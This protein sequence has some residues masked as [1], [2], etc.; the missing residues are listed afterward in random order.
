MSHPEYENVGNTDPVNRV[1]EE[2]GE[3]LFHLGKANRFGWFSCH[4][5]KPE[6]PNNLE[7]V[8]TEIQDLRL[9]LVRLDALLDAH[10]QQQLIVLREQQ[11]IHDAF[12]SLT[13]D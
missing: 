6:G 9:Q 13:L 7:D 2:V 4:P 5:N 3:L 1:I 10:E 8:R 11:I 12:K